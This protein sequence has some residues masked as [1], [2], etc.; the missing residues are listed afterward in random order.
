MMRRPVTVLALASAAAWAG[1]G[2]ALL[3]GAPARWYALALGVAL[4]TA[5]GAVQAGIT[6]MTDDQIAA[7][8]TQAMREAVQHSRRTPP[9]PPGGSVRYIGER[10]ARKDGSR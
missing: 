7:M 4:V 3:T 8:L 6:R 1:T 2:A 10:A 9:P 5:M